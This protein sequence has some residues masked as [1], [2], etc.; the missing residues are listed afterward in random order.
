MP[1][2]IR[3][4][5]QS[6]LT[7]DIK[8]S[9]RPNPRT[10]RNV[11]YLPG[12]TGRTRTNQSDEWKLKPIK[13][14]PRNLAQERY[15]DALMDSRNSIVIATGPAGTG[16]SLLATQYAIQQL[17]EGNIDRIVITR[18]AIG[19]NEEEHGFLPG[20][21]VDKL[22]PWVQPII[23]IFKEHYP[24]AVI[25]GMI[26]HGVIEF[27]PVAFVRGRT[28]KRTTVIFDE[29]QNSLPTAMKAVLT[30]IG[31]GSR[32]FVTGDMDQHDRGYTVNGLRD[33]ITRLKL[34][35]GVRHI[36]HCEFARTDIE[37]HPCVDEVLSLY[38]DT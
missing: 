2:R 21:I 6:Q 17:Q 27:V 24:L 13:L 34:A 3:N 36:A 4:A 11:V 9:D 25:I 12:L 31:E 16:K 38:E 10:D 28:F 8:R 14:L 26:E 18:P 15:I 22:M 1:R 33:F 7:R 32:I 35:D 29:A 37:R 5:K 23:D 30:R 19:V 20:T